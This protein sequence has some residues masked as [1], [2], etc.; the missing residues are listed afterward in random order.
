[1]SALLP[2]LDLSTYGSQIFW[3]VITFSILY[4]SLSRVFLPSIVGLVKKRKNYVDSIRQDIGIE[5]SH[6]IEL[7][8]DKLSTMNK[9]NSN[10]NDI[11][12]SA[13]AK[14]EIINS[15]ARDLTENTLIAMQDALWADLKLDI[16]GD[17]DIYKNDS[18]EIF[19][20]LVDLFS[21]KI[22][23]PKELNLIFENNWSK[24]TNNMIKQ[25]NRG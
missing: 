20:N 15:D 1:M 25:Y 19:E 3:L 6:I 16:E 13:K 17:K 11:L 2:Q 22:G 18:V 14:I 9:T 5:N 7:E 4:L 21:L 23:L 10:I 12:K 8:H 24:K